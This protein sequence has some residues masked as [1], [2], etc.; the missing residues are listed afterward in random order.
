MALL[1]TQE[2]IADMVVKAGYE[3][4]FDRSNVSRILCK[5]PEMEKLTKI[6]FTRI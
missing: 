3:K 1:C 6:Q 4:K 5:F 2:E